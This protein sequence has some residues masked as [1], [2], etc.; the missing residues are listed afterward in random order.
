MIVDQSPDRRNIL[1]KIL[2]KSGYVNIFATSGIED[3]YSMVSQVHPDV[4]L[5]E[6]ESPNRDTLEQLKAIRREQPLPVVM[7]ASDHDVQTVRAAVDSGVCAYLCDHVDPSA[8]KPAIALAMATFDAYRKVRK[9][10]DK[11]RLELD[12]RKRID[13]AKALLIKERGISEGEA[14][15]T[16]RKMAMDQ[17]QKLSVIAEQVILRHKPLG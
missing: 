17:N 9:E 15:R 3:L 1:E 6:L 2:R 5:I 16:I 11:Y 13:R 10:A 7:F 14:H 12:S 8:V 4:V